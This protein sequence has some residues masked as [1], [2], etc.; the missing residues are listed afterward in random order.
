[1]NVW[2]PQTVNQLYSTQIFQRPPPFSHLT[3]IQ[4]YLLF[5]CSTSLPFFLHLHLVFGVPPLFPP[6]LPLLFLAL[7]LPCP[8]SSLLFSLAF[9]TLLF[10]PLLFSIGVNSVFS[11]VLP[12]VLSPVLFFFPVLC[13]MIFLDSVLFFFFPF[14]YIKKPHLH[15][16]SVLQTYI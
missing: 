6:C 9:P 2:L 13:P 14:T 11:V 8:C 10:P 7:S 5:L 1:M 16:P 3:C 12:L 15:L 4:F